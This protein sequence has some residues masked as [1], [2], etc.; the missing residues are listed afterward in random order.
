MRTAVESPRRDESTVELVLQD[1]D[2]IVED[3]LRLEFVV[4][5]DAPDVAPPTTSTTTTTTTVPPVEDDAADA[6]SSV[7]TTPSPSTTSATTST[8]ISTAPVD[9]TDDV[10]E[11]PI[12]AD[13]SIITT[14]RVGVHPAI[15]TR[16]GAAVLR[17]GPV[18]PSALGEAMDTVEVEV[19]RYA[20]VDPDTGERRLKVTTPMRVSGDKGSDTSRDPRDTGTRPLPHHGLTPAR[21]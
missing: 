21:R 2:F 16:V 10:A 12:D 17:T 1:L 4:V 11:P 19:S 14:V 9:D 6:G 20:D 18:I 13:P 15:E 5:G 7:T 8:T 3:A